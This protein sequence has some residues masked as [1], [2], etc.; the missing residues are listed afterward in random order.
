MVSDI[1][2]KLFSPMV[3]KVYGE[4]T[5]KRERR[6]RDQGQGISFNGMAPTDLLPLTS[7][8]LEKFLKIPNIAPASE[9]PGIHH[10][11]LFFKRKTFHL[12]IIMGHLWNTG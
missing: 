1:Q 4:E 2:A 10:I 8:Y 5:Q 11:N 3:P 6:R 9:G 12:R 7:L